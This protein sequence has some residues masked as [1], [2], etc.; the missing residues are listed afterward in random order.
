MSAAV[1]WATVA[2]VLAL[3]WLAGGRLGQPAP[4]VSAQDRAFLV[5]VHRSNLA[6][7]TAGQTAQRQAS[8]TGV[9]ALAGQLVADYGSLDA[10]L[11]DVATRLGVTLPTRP[12][13][14]EQRQLAQLAART[15]TDLDLAWIAGQI[16]GD[17][18]A[19]AAGEA[20]LSRGRS[21]K[22]TALARSAT[23]VLERHLSM[24]QQLGGGRVASGTTAGAGA[25]PGGQSGWARPAAR[26]LTVLGLVLI[27][28]AAL[29]P[30]RSGPGGPRLPGPPRPQPP[31]PPELRPP[32]RRMPE[33]RFTLPVS[34][35]AQ[36][37]GAAAARAPAGA[38]RA[39]WQRLG[40]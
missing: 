38:T 35:T 21:A 36:P 7:I 19:I 22:V 24:L 39:T 2:G 28:F 29:F 6:A 14:G 27:A 11:K 20:Q 18:Q 16:A 30:G 1:R 25:R 9:R 26:I 23:P 3:L 33:R 15:G 37:V 32:L 4:S 31:Q 40:R 13:A 12:A 8:A 17:Q 5:A 10:E 34:V